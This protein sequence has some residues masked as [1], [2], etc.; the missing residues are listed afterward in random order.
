M[1]TITY[2]NPTASPVVTTPQPVGLR[3]V[4]TQGLGKWIDAA[5]TEKFRPNDPAYM[6]RAGADYAGAGVVGQPGGV[7]AAGLGL[8]SSGLAQWFIIGSIIGLVLLLRK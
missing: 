6:T 8:G 5:V 7:L 3:D 2:N 1:A 4:L